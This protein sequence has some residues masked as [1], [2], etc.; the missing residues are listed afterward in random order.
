MVS[1]PYPMGQQPMSNVSY[2]PISRNF[3]ERTQT[4][5][6][7]QFSMQ[8]VK[9]SPKHTAL[10]LYLI[11]LLRPIW[12]K[13]CIISPEGISSLTHAHCSDILHE[14]YAFKAF[15]EDIPLNN[16]SGN[17]ECNRFLDHSFNAFIFFR[18]F[19]D[20]RLGQ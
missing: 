10:Y 3:G 19:H 20:Q 15:L 14:L 4:Q 18:F 13:K 5:Q 6:P 8:D 1:T 16:L 11:H 12:K 2:S 9:Y 17:I 7:Q